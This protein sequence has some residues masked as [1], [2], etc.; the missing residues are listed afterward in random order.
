VLLTLRDD[1]YSGRTTK[2]GQRRHARLN[3]TCN[4]ARAGA[5]RQCAKRPIGGVHPA[6]VRVERPG[7]PGSSSVVLRQ[8]AYAAPAAAL[9]R[10]F[11]ER[12]DAR[13]RFDSAQLEGDDLARSAFFSRLTVR[14]DGDAV[15]PAADGRR[16]G[17]GRSV[18]NARALVPGD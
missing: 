4:L 8:Y 17:L 16:A 3:I 10:A 11:H 14:A 13:R 5:K 18:V 15:R 9:E 7:V 6:T 1:V 12:S 2:H